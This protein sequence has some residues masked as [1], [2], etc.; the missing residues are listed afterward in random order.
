[1]SQR[2]MK[3]RVVAQGVTVALMVATSGALSQSSLFSSAPTTTPA[4]GEE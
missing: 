4:S 3:A 1:M 2:M